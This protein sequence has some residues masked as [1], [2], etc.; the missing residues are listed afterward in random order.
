LEHIGMRVIGGAGVNLHVVE[1][2]KP[3]GQPL[4]FIHGFCQSVFAWRKQFASDL[5]SDFRLIAFDLR[6]HG[7]SDKPL[8]AEAYIE[9]KPWADDV[10]AVID[11]LNLRDAVL[12]GW[13]YAGY[14]IADYLRAYG[15]NRTSA[16][17][18]V[19]ALTVKGG[20]KARGFTGP[21][22]AQLYPAM[23]SPDLEVL[24]P[25]MARFVDMCYADPAQLPENDRV[26][27]LEIGEKPPAVARESMGRRKLDNDDVLGALRIP[28]LCVHG[29]EDAI[30]TVASSEHNARVI[31]GAR[32][33]LYEDVG[34]TP[35]VEDVERFNAELRE[36]AR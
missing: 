27:L 19:S 25:A 29:M 1:G 8:E 23:N 26:K 3:Q 36:L 16:V 28:V 21:R 31:P 35:F 24:R 10:A 17:A 20:E 34:H 4:L 6:G 18:F 22:F 9:S 32:L 13:S 15:V 2:G 30:V 12:V 5:A 14:V 11:S 7:D 33:S